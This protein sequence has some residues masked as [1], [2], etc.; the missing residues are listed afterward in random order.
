MVQVAICIPTY[1]QAEYLL[2]ALRSAKQQTY[3]Q[4][5]IW[6]ADDASTDNTPE[7]MAL[8]RHS[9]QIRYH[10]HTQN[11]GIAQNVNW[12]LRQPQTE[13]IV[14]LDSDDL[15]HPRYV[16]TLLKLMCEYPS[17]G[18]AHADV[19][20]I[21]ER[22]NHQRVRRLARQEEFQ[23]SEKALLASV[24]GY[25]VAANICMFRTAA[26]RKLNF[27]EGRPTYTEDYDLSV[28]MAD[29]GYG[30][31]YSHQILSSYRVWT[32]K[33]KVRSKRTETELHGIIQVFDRAIVPAFER[34]D[35]D[36][37]IV[38]HQRRKM[39]L[40]YSTLLDSKHWNSSEKAVI[41]KLLK[42][43]GDSPDLQR[44]L[45]LLN[46]GFGAYFRWQNTIQIQLKDQ[47]KQWLTK[48]RD[49]KSAIA[50]Q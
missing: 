29:M 19:Q 35:W 21:D 41:I 13:F 38:N 25:R 47:L 49:R 7:V 42:E 18:Y 8:C 17:A 33:N 26:L 34:R 39:A 5:E 37:Q 10:R 28:R 6:V 2:E 46:W 50:T 31:V 15:L 24:H 32:D 22:G 43:L 36:T 4:I 30:N 23:D 40:T 12:L 16:E 44:R 11:L 20:E 45:Q 27:T 14:R 48:W 9:P 3:P 1:N